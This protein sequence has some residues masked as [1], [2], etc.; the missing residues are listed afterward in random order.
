VSQGASL[1]EQAGGTMGE[2]VSAITKVNDIVGEIALASKEQAVGVAQVSEA[3][4][5]MDQ[6]TQ[7]NAA[8]VEQCAAAA[9]SLDHQTHR[10]V[11][12]AARFRLA[13]PAAMAG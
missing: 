7:Q 2:I 4:S 12:A 9:M 8:L 1:V 5:E 13:G 10:L 11:E 3:V 6:T